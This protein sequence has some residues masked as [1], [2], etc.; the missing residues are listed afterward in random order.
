MSKENKHLRPTVEYV[1]GNLEVTYYGRCMTPEEFITKVCDNID[2][3]ESELS[4]YRW[5]SVTEPP[6]KTTKVWVVFEDEDGKR[7][8]KEAL[9]ADQ[10]KVFAVF[11]LHQRYSFYQDRIS[12]WMPIPALPPVEDESNGIS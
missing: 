6:K 7:A 8:V 11:R 4:Q 9:Y 1:V 3:L 10:E 12:H 5:V 2:A